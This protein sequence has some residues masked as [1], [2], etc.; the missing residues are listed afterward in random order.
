MPD[1]PKDNFELAEFKTLKEEIK[2]QTSEKAL[3]ERQV[4]LG[5]SVL[6]AVLATMSRY[7]VDP[8]ILPFTKI[9][10]FAPPVLILLAYLRWKSYDSGISQMGQ[11]I[12]ETYKYQTWEGSK[13]RTSLWEY[14]VLNRIVWPLLLGA[15]LLVAFW[16]LIGVSPS[17]SAG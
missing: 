13:A 10:W 7:G 3:L 8:T 14:R 9:L 12:L 16:F 5:M 1:T 6:Y 2:T 17:E 11:H 15:S 4:I